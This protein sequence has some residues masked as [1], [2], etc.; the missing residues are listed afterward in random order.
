MEGYRRQ[1]NRLMDLA[2]YFTAKIR[3]TEGYELVIDP[4]SLSNLTYRL[5]SVTVRHQ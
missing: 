4:V 2:A 3:Q 5:I 1:I